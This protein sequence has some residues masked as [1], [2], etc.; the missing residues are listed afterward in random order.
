MKTN[1][2]RKTK[3]LTETQLRALIADE[4]KLLGLTFDDAVKRAKSRTLPRTYIGDDLALLIE[5]LPV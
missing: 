4:A 2:R 1:G 5:L 3:I